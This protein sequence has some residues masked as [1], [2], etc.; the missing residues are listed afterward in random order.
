MP[1][2][3][4]NCG[5]N[6]YGDEERLNKK[7]WATHKTC[8]DC[9]VTMETRLRAE[10]KFEEYE[11]KKMHENAKSFF[12]SADK[13]VE[14][15]KKAVEGKL[16]FVQNAQGET[17]EFDQSDFKEKYLNYIDTQY[18]RFKTETL[19]ELKNKEK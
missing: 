14:I 12:K 19:S 10:G 7:F 1:S 3:C 8:F 18:N 6:M 13:E 9:V 17:E 2:K 4:P 5:N 15:L 11:R 16:E